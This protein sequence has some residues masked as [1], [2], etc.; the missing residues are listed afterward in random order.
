MTYFNPISE[1]IT[2]RFTCPDCGEEVVSDA[3]WV[4]LPDF[5]AENNSDSMNYENYEVECGSCGRSFEVTIYNAMYDGE[6]EVEDVDEVEVEEEF[7]DEDMDYEKYVFDVTPEK[8]SDVLDEIE[9][10]SVSTKEYLYRQL[11]AG[12]ITSMEA[13]LSS[14]LIRQVLSSEDLKRKFVETY[15]PY[16]EEQMPFSDLYKKLDTIDSKIQKT[17]RELMYHNLGKIKPIYKDTLDIDMGDISEV[18]KAVLVRHD[19]IHRSGKDKDGKLHEV[20]KEDVIALVE[21]VSS[22]ISRVEGQLTIKSIPGA[23]EVFTNDSPLPRDVRI[24]F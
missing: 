22:I 8:I 19:I 7:A 20:K 10:L 13:F 6:V 21:N 15:M 1:S 18:M 17:L 11:Y 5:S 4:P 23:D 2:L 16:R 9:S 14:T 12:A 3:F 24:P